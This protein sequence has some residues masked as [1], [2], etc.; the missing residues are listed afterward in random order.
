MNE[1]GTVLSTI[2]KHVL[3]VIVLHGSAYQ[4][5]PWKKCPKENG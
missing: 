1:P 5:N 4:H 3:P 2:L